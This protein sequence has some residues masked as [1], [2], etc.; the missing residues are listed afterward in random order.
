MTF[1]PGRTYIYARHR[2]VNVLCMQIKGNR[3]MSIQFNLT[4]STGKKRD[5]DI[6]NNVRAR[7]VIYSTAVVM[8]EYFRPAEH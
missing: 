3:A 7:F 1:D 5:G 2:V 6:K 8:P 4:V